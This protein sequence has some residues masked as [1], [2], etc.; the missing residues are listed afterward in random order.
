MT[1]F[2]YDYYYYL[3][4]VGRRFDGEEVKKGKRGRACVVVL[5]DIGRSPRMQYHALS[6]ARQVL[7]PSNSTALF[8]TMYMF[9]LAY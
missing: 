2:I 5:G 6:L 7:F 3:L 1:D 8:L 9:V 4:M